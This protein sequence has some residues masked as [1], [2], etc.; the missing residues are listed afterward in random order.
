MVRHNHPAWG[1]DKTHDDQKP[2]FDMVIYR[3]SNCGWALP[4]NGYDLVNRCPW[5]KIE[6]NDERV[7]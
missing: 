5:C 3:C 2:D 1:R 4:E 6:L 7:K